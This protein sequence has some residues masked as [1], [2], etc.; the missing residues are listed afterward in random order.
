MRNLLVGSS[1]RIHRYVHGDRVQALVQSHLEG[2]QD[3][4]QLLW[5]L[6]TFELWLRQLERPVLIPE[7]N[8]PVMD[9]T[10]IGTGPREAGKQA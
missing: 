2:K 1:P 3:Q 7:L 10:P 6:V 8:R 9:R 4:G 5:L